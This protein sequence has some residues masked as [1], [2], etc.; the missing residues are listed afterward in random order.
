MSG[1]ATEIDIAI[2]GAGFSGLYMLKKARDE[3]GLSATVLEAGED[4]GGAWYWNK[5]PGLRC[6]SPSH[7][8]C[9]SFD[10]E[11]TDEW[12]WSERYPQRDEIFA[13]L[14]HVA[15]RY[16]LRRDID[17]GQFV[18]SC[19]YDEQDRTWTLATTNG[20][21]YRARF[22]VAGT[23]CLTASQW[24]DIS[25][26]ESFEGRSFHTSRWPE[27]GVDFTGK[28]VAVIGTG[29][30]GVQ[31]IPLIA[32]QAK[33]LTVF[34]RTATY[35]IPAR[36]GQVD[37][38]VV[39]DQK[40]RKSEIRERIKH[41]FFGF[42][43]DFLET[44]IFDATPEE[45]R[46]EFDRM[47]EQG[48]FAFWLG[49]YSE[50]FFSEEANQIISEY[51]HEK[52]RETVFD[53]ATAE[54]LVPKYGFGTKRSPLETNYYEAFNKR[55]V[56]LIDAATD[57]GIE[58]ITPT[59]IRAGGRDFDFDIIVYATGF[60]AMT[61]ALKNMNIVG[62]DGLA[63]NDA[64][65]D[66]PETYLGLMA[67][68]FPNLFMITGPQSPSAFSNVP[69]SI[70]QHVEFIADCISHLKAN[71]LQQIEPTAEAQIEWGKHLQE[72]VDQTILMKTDSW[73]VGS[74]VPGKPRRFMIYLGPEGVGGYR[75][76]CD[77]IVADGYRGF[78]LA[79]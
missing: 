71:D 10:P 25:G 41:S 42:E 59:G 70:E 28:R 53:P 68:G 27:G 7:I 47:W 17:F 77:E 3:L 65:A 72:I 24:P 4:V 78:E 30:T 46:Q 61:G 66:G 2:I 45:R 67:A 8:Y 79:S 50:M 22:V 14:R 74:N 48:G 73:Y 76:T 38:E 49:N 40:V 21:T 16:D 52:I 75:R 57:G 44:S 34:Q 37:P 23:G 32:L 1:M 29:A 58:A 39:A 62:R 26:R 51:L 15:D 11:L 5:Y 18:T 19:E 35:C 12:K 6:D 43:H 13:Y 56:E 54:K 20:A 9:Y 31:C 63:L 55:N 69:V 64:W 36:N 33:H 60:D